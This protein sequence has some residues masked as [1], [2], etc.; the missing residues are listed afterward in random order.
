MTDTELLD[1]LQKLFDEHVVALRSCRS[2]VKIDI[3][4]GEMRWAD[5]TQAP[6]VTHR[7]YFGG[8]P[9]S[10]YGTGPDVRAAIA[11]AIAAETT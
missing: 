4:D 7:D 8:G 9:D 6:P 10:P 1:G 2:G 5:A 11:K 3:A